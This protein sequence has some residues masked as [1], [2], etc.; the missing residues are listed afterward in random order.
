MSSLKPEGYALSTDSF[1]LK[2]VFKHK[3]FHKLVTFR[4]L[5]ESGQ[6]RVI[7]LDGHRTISFTPTENGDNYIDVIVTS[8]PP[9]R[10]CS[11]FIFGYF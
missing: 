8:A 6:N 5:D 4:G 10:K 9:D 3:D 1:K 7:L 11:L 2:I